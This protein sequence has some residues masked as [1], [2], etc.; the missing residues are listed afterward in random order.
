MRGILG[1]LAP[2]AFCES[3][4][5]LELGAIR[6]R[7]IKG[8]ILDLDNTLVEW[9]APSPGAELRQWI[10]RVREAGLS[11][12]VVSNNSGPR[13]ALFSR[14]LGIPAVPLA[15]KPRRRAFLQ[16]MAMMGTSPG[17]TAVIGDQLFTDILGGNR[18]GLYTILVRPMTGREFIGTRLVRLVERIVLRQLL[19]QGR[20]PAG[21]TA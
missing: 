5:E 7:G 3:V 2:A 9:N 4:Y 16:A 14:E 11:A 12:C 10:A 13:V 20:F 1:I 15:R 21:P 8:L 6:G 19:R 18:L 17:E